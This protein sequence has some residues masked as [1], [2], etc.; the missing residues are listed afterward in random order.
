MPGA[1]DTQIRTKDKPGVIPTPSQNQ[2]GYNAGRA[3]SCLHPFTVQ[4][5][6]V[7]H[8]RNHWVCVPTKC[9]AFDPDRRQSASITAPLLMA[10][11]MHL[12]RAQTK[13][14]MKQKSEMQGAMSLQIHAKHKPGTH[15]SSSPFALLWNYRC[16]AAQ[17]VPW[18]HRQGVCVHS[19]PSTLTKLEACAPDLDPGS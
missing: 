9:R 8:A 17:A 15:A 6:N 12:H 5:Q 4:H 2:Q 1:A 14:K 11:H 13:H 3:K 16:T 18:L 10:Q 7:A 19:H